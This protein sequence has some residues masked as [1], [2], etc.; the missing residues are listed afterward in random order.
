M[1]GKFEY[2][3]PKSRL[4]LKRSGELTLL[5]KTRYLQ[6]GWVRL[7]VGLIWLGLLMFSLVEFGN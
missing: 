7:K 2:K 4:N 5:N 1:G 3:D 6:I